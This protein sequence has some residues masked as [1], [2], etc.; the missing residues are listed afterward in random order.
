[1]AKEVTF[2][3]SKRDGPSCEVAF[4]E[5]ETLDDPRWNE[6]VADP[7]TDINTLALKSLRVAIQAGAREELDDGEAAVQAYV[8]E[9]VYRGGGRGIRVKKAPVTK[10]LQKR[11]K[12]SPE[13]IEALRAAGFPIEAEVAE[14][15]EAA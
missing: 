13:Q 1:M 4:M 12:F 14:E 2:A 3:V 6:L 10:D 11:A 7:K 9:Y 5:P 15:P 8:N